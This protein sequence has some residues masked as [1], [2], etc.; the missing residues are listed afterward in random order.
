MPPFPVGRHE[1][2]F[3]FEV[4]LDEI[5]SDLD[6][7]VDAVFACLDSEFLVLPKGRGF[8][9]F[10]TFEAGY[11]ALKRATKNF[12]AVTPESLAQVV[13]ETPISLIVLRCMLGF[14]PPEWA[15]YASRLTGFAISRSAAR[16]IDRKIRLAPG[17][18]LPRDG[19]LTERRIHA[20]VTAACHVLRYRQT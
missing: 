11:E 13:F 20:L 5:E 3:P 4:S 7:H 14:T 18:S 2:P 9:A 6:S 16:T 17:V 1:V 12:T 15:Y 8:V 19:S 10:S